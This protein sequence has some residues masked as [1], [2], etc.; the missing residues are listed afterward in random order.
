[1]LASRRSPPRP[2]GS[3]AG[4]AAPCRVSCAQTALWREPHPNAIAPVNSPSIKRIVFFA[5]LIGLTVPALLVFGVNYLYSK[6]EAQR[7]Q[8]ER[9]QYY[10]NQLPESLRAPLWNLDNPVAQ[11]ILDALHGDPSVV[12]ARVQ[13]ATLGEVARVEWP[14]SL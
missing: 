8:G 6:E 4:L 11:R 2:P 1:M 7:R 13:D 14:E 10:R 3:T 12:S 9:V 5:M